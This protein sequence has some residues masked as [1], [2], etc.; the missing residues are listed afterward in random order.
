ML[1]LET[2]TK[3]LQHQEGWES[4]VTFHVLCAHVHGH[5]C[6]DMSVHVEGR[7]LAW[8]IILHCSPTLLRQGLLAKLV[9]MAGFARQLTLGT[10]YL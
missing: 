7:R 1:W 6:L 10:S 4:L 2:C 3:G 5:M 8:E 9:N